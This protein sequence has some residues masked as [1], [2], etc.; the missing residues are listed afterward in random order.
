M[1]KANIIASTVL[2]L[3]SGFLWTRVN[4]IKEAGYEV[5]GSKVF[6]HA[7]LFLIIIASITVI[8]MTLKNKEE[9]GTAFATKAQFIR[10]FVTF[11]LFVL[12]IAALE[13]VGFAISNIAFL[14]VLSSFF[15]G[16][17]DKGLIKIAIFSVIATIAL[18][19]LFNN[20]F[21]VLLP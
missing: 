20:F 2:I 17:T 18:Y 3:I 9:S 11:V 16:K 1:R 7:V 5:I 13:Y 21:G 15:Y 14:F 8:G 10:T 4:V 12:Y 6:P 19:Y